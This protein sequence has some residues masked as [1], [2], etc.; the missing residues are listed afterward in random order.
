MLTDIEIDSLQIGTRPFCISPQISYPI[1]KA[2]TD[3][4][5]K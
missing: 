1:I 2:T 5:L 3:T 4:I